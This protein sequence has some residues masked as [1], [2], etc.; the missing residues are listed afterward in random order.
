M[1]CKILLI[2][3]NEDFL[4]TLSFELR[5]RGF[6][7][8][9]AVDCETGLQIVQTAPVD[10]VFL[11]ILMPNVDGAETLRRIR[12]MK[13]DLPVIVV[14]GYPNSPLIDLAKP[15]GISGVFMKGSSLQHLL[16]LVEE[17]MQGHQV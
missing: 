9:T 2:D 8:M 15:L 10:V 13:K 3:D 11:D 16:E 1:P 7:V 17:A 6:W 5:Q 14:T 12:K 4:E